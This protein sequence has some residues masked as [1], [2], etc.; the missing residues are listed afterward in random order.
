MVKKDLKDYV[1]TK[2][3]YIVFKITKVNYTDLNLGKRLA[4][5]TKNS[6]NFR[7]NF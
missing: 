1:L 7:P 4:P 6:P 5:L 3:Q 2:C